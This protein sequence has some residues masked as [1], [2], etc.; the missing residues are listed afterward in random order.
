MQV[1]RQ[2]FEQ[3]IVSMLIFQ[4][5]MIG[6]CS[7]KTAP[8]QVSYVGT[9][10]LSLLANDSKGAASLHLPQRCAQWYVRHHGRLSSC[11]Y[12]TGPLL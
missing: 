4:L 1:W 7:L 11:L 6:L 9:I 2:V 5:L 8:I 10:H 3:V 12:H